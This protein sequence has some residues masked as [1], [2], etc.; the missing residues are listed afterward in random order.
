MRNILEQVFNH[1][2]STDES[3]RGIIQIRDY[4]LSE[5]NKIEIVTWQVDS[6]IIEIHIMS[7]HSFDSVAPQLSNWWCVVC[8]AMHKAT[9]KAATVYRRIYLK[10]NLQQSRRSGPITNEILEIVGEL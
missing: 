2:Q 8:T 5:P 1:N 6:I 9:D 4:V 10:I 7:R 3:G